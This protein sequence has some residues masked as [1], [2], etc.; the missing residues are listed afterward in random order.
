MKKKVLFHQ[1]NA[2]TNTSENVMSKI[3]DLRF[4]LLSYPPYLPDLSTSNYYLS[5]NLKKWFRGQRFSSNNEVIAAVDG[6]FE[7][8]DVSSY[9][10]GIKKFSQ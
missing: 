3:H 6:Y 1:D 10:A 2:P 5:P 9:A 4:E 7:D 8:L